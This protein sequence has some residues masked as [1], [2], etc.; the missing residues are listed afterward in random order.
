M[1]ILYDLLI[2]AVSLSK[3]TLKALS[4]LQCKELGLHC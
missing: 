2:A 1:A 4:F 3:V